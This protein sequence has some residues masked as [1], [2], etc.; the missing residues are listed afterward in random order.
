VQ[1]KP[2]KH[3]YVPQ[4]I[5]RKFCN[6]DTTSIFVFDTL[7]K[8]TFSQSPSNILYEKYLYSFDLSGLRKYKAY[9]NSKG[10]PDIYYSAKMIYENKMSEIDHK[11]SHIYNF[12]NNDSISYDENALLILFF[13]INYFRSLKIYENQ[14]HGSEFFTQQ[15]FKS[16]RE[17]NVSED[18]IE[19]YYNEKMTEDE[20]KLLFYE[21]IFSSTNEL[22]EFFYDYFC[23][24]LESNN[25][26]IL[27]D[28][29]FTCLN[30]YRDDINNNG[31]GKNGA[32]FIGSISKNLNL[33]LLPRHLPQSL[34]NTY[35]D[36]NINNVDPYDIIS[37]VKIKKDFSKQLLMDTMRMIIPENDIN[38]ISLIHYKCN[39]EDVEVL[40]NLQIM[41]SYRFIISEYNI[42]EKLNKFFLQNKEL[43]NRNTNILSEFYKIDESK[44][45]FIYSNKAKLTESDE[46]LQRYHKPEI[47]L[48]RSKNFHKSLLYKIQQ[49][50]RLSINKNKT[51]P[52]ILDYKDST[53][54]I[55]KN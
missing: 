17:H 18:E 34:I 2:I 11:I 5:I 25:Q 42:S 43:N 22:L 16:L 23:I 14:R 24:I 33:L 36:I 20:I 26:F 13:A 29:P 55:K 19:K 32:F 50:A 15:I 38:K 4:F 49:C 1:K 6:D 9:I 7:R 30:L 44:S 12:I 27:G 48:Y 37:K 39:N 8:E 21:T 47:N 52:G 41:N 28:T 45:H 53:I 51:I 46:I 3:H 10:L 54:C 35:D 31:P 40:N